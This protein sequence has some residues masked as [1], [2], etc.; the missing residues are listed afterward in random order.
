MAKLRLVE[1][2][3]VD[4]ETMLVVDGKPC[5]LKASGYGDFWVVPPDGYKVCRFLKDKGR[6]CGCANATV[7]SADNLNCGC[8]PRAD[9]ETY[10]LTVVELVDGKD[11]DRTY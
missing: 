3:K 6:R 4:T 7:V 11:P 2:V 9:P 10:P 1:K 8:A 5:K